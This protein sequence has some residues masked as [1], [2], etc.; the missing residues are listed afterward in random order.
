M[1]GITK[2]IQKAQGTSELASPEDI[3]GLKLEIDFLSAEQDKTKLMLVQVL[4]M[5]KKVAVNDA[6][7]RL[8]IKNMKEKGDHLGFEGD[9]F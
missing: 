7:V 1:I 3:K 9:T 4:E 8:E 6:D 5:L 2:A